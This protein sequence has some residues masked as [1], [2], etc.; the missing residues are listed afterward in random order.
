MAD[1]LHPLIREYHAV[2]TTLAEKNNELHDLRTRANELEA[3]MTNV[4]KSLNNG[5]P[6]TVKFSDT[7]YTMK[8]SARTSTL[9]LAFL[10]KWVPEHWSPTSTAED[11]IERLWNARPTTEGWA[12]S[13][14]TPK[15]EVKKTARD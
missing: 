3:K 1:Q 8:S 9:T 5:A 10:K 2:R 7:T 13:T 14:T 11:F 4:A 15:G 6:V 12:V